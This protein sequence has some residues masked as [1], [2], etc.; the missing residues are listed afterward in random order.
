[1]ALSRRVWTWLALGSASGFLGSVLLGWAAWV[2]LPRWAPDWVI[3][4]SPFIEPIVRAYAIV[5][6]VH[7]TP[8]TNRGFPVQIDFGPLLVEMAERLRSRDPQGHALMA[9]LDSDD[10]D[11]RIKALWMLGWLDLPQRSV[12]KH[13]SQDANPWIRLMAFERQTAR[14]RG[15]PTSPEDV[16]VA[17]EIAVDFLDDPDAFLHD[18]A[19]DYLIRHPEQAWTHRHR[20]F[21]IL[22]E[23]LPEKSLVMLWYEIWMEYGSTQ[24]GRLP[25]DVLFPVLWLAQCGSPEVDDERVIRT[26][27]D[28]AAQDL[29]ALHDVLS[30]MH[31]GERPWTLGAEPWMYEVLHRLMT[32]RIICSQSEVA[33]D[34][35]AKQIFPHWNVF[36]DPY[37]T[38]S[39]VESVP[40]KPGIRSGI[41]VIQEVSSH[42]GGS[43][44]LRNGVICV[45]SPGRDIFATSLMQGFVPTPRIELGAGSASTD[46]MIQRWYAALARQCKPSSREM[47]L[48]EWL[49][50]LGRQ[51]GVPITIAPNAGPE[52]LID[53]HLM[54]LSL[55]EVL[56][57]AAGIWSLR[58]ELSESGIQIR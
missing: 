43:L 10:Q 37:F 53:V 39:G 41:E 57:F 18:E 22:N 44:Q 26:L 45:I 32:E 5:D 17:A 9:C 31:R 40:I 51:T 23:Q 46:P 29:P 16:D 19:Y 12:I 56:R 33:P 28:R 21:Q 20:L 25:D 7:G 27:M 2:F 1:M 24:S 6:P 15:T 49:S 13:L 34:Q 54:G 38:S 55:E 47:L 48:G 4:H 8:E 58:V 50:D 36:I 35:I 14:A 52:L 42:L 3:D 30:A 11:K